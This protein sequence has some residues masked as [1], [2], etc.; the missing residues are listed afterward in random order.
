MKLFFVITAL[1]FAQSAFAEKADRKKPVYLEADRATVEDVNRKESSRI[2]IFT[3]NVILT[4]GTMRILADKLV[5]KEDLDGFKH[6]TATGDLV[7]FRQ[8]RDGLDEYVEGWS[9]RVEYD[10]K[11]DKIELFRQA[12][13][14]RGVDEVQGD[15]ISYDMNTEFFKVIG[16]KERGV[17]TGPD[18]RVRITIQPKNKSE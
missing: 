2:S 11:T 17:E 15:Y 6:A 13:L 7:S 12:R 3:G 10:S 16:S 14:K 1:L 9:Q 18:K 5:M 8:K 4:Q